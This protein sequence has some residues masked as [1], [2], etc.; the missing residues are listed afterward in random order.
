M[1]IKT[2]KEFD[3][4]IESWKKGFRDALFGGRNQRQ[5]AVDSESYAKGHASAITRNEESFKLPES[6]DK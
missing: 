4:E 2:L 6:W 1:S 5:Y 3:I